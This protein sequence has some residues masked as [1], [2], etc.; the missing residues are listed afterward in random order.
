[1]PP[2]TS[3]FRPRCR[4]RESSERGATAAALPASEVCWKGEL[5]NEN[6]AVMH[7]NFFPNERWSSA[8]RVRP[9]PIQE[10]SFSVGC[11]TRSRFFSSSRFPRPARVNQGLEAGI[12]PALGGYAVFVGTSQN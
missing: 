12:V 7:G 8:V 11:R 1:M 6:S 5:S 3:D 2:L 10:G 4:S 9:S